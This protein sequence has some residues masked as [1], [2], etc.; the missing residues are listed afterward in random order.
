MKCAR[1]YYVSLRRFA[2]VGSRQ[3]GGEAD[4]RAG[5]VSMRY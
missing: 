5:T 3:P 4:Q 1:G 2:A